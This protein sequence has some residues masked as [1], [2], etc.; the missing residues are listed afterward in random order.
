MR[1]VVLDTETTGLNPRNGDRL[2]EIGCIELYNHIPTGK[3]YHQYINPKRDIP[4][5]AFQ[6]HGLSEEFLKDKPTIEQIIPEFLKFIK[7]DTLIIHNAKF[8]VGF[9]N[10]EL[11]KS[12]FSVLKNK[13]I[14]TLLI[15][16]KKF[17]KTKVNLDSLCKK[18]NINNSKR[19][20][21]GALLDSEILAEVY[22]ELI[23]QK[24]PKLQLFTKQNKIVKD[25]KKYEKI[26]YKPRS[27]TVDT[28]DF[29]NHKNHVINE[30]KGGIWNYKT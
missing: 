22:L 1:E 6:V 28:K 24:E 7:D 13:V 5:E 4:K 29:N 14:D 21:H 27:F 23:E 9:L 2:I 30:L 20:L 3:F 18:F 12:G 19:K 10:H 16:R 25:K 17:P 8:D 26:F 15:A 11:L